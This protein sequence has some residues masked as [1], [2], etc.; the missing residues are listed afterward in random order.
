MNALRD[1]WLSR[2]PRDRWVYGG[3]AALVVLVVVYLAVVEPLQ[4][5]RDQLERGVASQRELLSWMHTVVVPA[6]GN[7]RAP[8]RSGNQS[9]FATVDRSARSTV[10]AGAVQ[11]VQPEGTGAVRVWLENAP[12]DATVR[13]VAQLEREHGIT[14]SALSVEPTEG[15]G[16][17]TVRLTLERA[18]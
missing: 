13:W 15:A 1:W 3:V 7:L 12:F 8:A 10:L 4:M 18:L 5:R 14:V 9:L 2:A 6:R 11:R 17:V 16:L